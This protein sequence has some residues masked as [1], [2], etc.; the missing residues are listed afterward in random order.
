MQASL[1]DIDTEAILFHNRWRSCLPAILKTLATFRAEHWFRFSSCSILRAIALPFGLALLVVSCALVVSC[2]DPKS[3]DS[4]PGQTQ[5]HPWP[6]VDVAEMIELPGLTG[7]PL[8]ERSTG[9]SEQMFTE[10]SVDESG[11]GFVSVVEPE[12][13]MA[14]LYRSGLACGGL[15]IG[16]VDGDGWPDVF[17]AGGAGKNRLYRQVGGNDGAMRFEDITEQAG[18]LG[19]GDDWAG[20]VSMA[21]IDGDGDL[22][23]YVVNYDAPNALFVNQGTS[24]SD[25]ASGKAN[26]TVQFTEQ[27][28]AFAVDIVDACQTSAF[29]DYD[30][31]G[32]LDLYV[33]TNRYED[34][35]GY[36]GNDAFTTVNGKR[37]L[38]PGYEKY[39]LLWEEGDEWGI[40]AYG[41]EDYLL[42]N[43]GGR[44]TDVS[45]SSGINGRGDGLSATWWDANADG[46]MDLYVG[47]DMISQDKF[48]INQGDGTFRDEIHERIPHS[49]WFSMGADVGDLNNDG[50][51]DFLIADMSA[52]NHFKQKTTMGVMGGPIL[53]AANSSLPPQYMRNALYL[54][55]GTARFLEG[56]FLAGLDS[57]DWTWAVKISDFD[58]DGWQDV[59]VSNGTARAMN[60]SDYTF[61]SEQLRD[62][63]EWH[64]LKSL[65]RREEKNRAMRNAASSLHF[66]DVSDAW[67]LGK[68]GVSYGAAS[69]DLDRDGDVDL[70]VINVEEPVSVYRNDSETGN[71]LILKLV[72]EDGKRLAIG[73]KVSLRAGGVQQQR[74]LAPTSG[75]MSMNEPMLHFGVG[76]AEVIERLVVS[77]PGGGVQEYAELPVNQYFVIRQETT[78][79]N[80]AEEEVLPMFA[81][82]DLSMQ[83]HQEREFDDFT[84]Q[85][86]L[87]N[88]LSQLGSGTAW[89]D[90]DGD[91]DDDL[92]VG[93]AAGQIAELRLNQGNGVFVAQWVEVLREDKA[94]EDMGAVFFDADSDGDQDLYVVSGSYEFPGNAPELADRLYLNDGKGGLSKAEAGTIP[95]DQ[96][97]GSIVAAADFDRDG[98]EDLFVGGRLIPGEYP[99]A[100]QSALLKNEGGKFTDIA[101]EI[102]GLK[103]SGM[104]TSALWSDA[105]DDGWFDLFVTHEWGS[106]QIFMNRAGTL[107]D[108]TVTAGLG[109]RLGWWNSIAGGD[110]DGDGDMDYAVGNHGLNSKYHASVDKPVQLYYGDYTGDGNMNLVEAE[111]EDDVLYPIRGKS[112]SSNAMPHLRDKFQSFRAFATAT[113][114]EIYS[115]ENLQEAHHFVA[116]TLESGLLINDGKGVFTWRALPQLAQIAP[117]FGLTFL[118]ADGDGNLDLFLAQ[119]F[120]GPQAETGRFD[121]GMSLLLRGDGAGG[122]APVGAEVSG[123]IISGDATSVTVSDIDGDHRPDLLVGVNDGFSIAWR[124]QSA[125]D[126]LV[127]RLVGSAAGARVTV[128]D[129]NGTTQ[130]QEIYSG[131]GYLSQGGRSLFFASKGAALTSLEVQWPDGSKTIQN[132][133]D[134]L[135]ALVIVAKEEQ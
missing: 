54:G 64:Y 57:T 62:H 132:I 48:Y 42:R 17:L 29:C 87:P 83:M 25:K 117:V 9:D 1:C 67:G 53:K 35:R 100:P 107:N 63:H 7:V 50:H 4:L 109:E 99:L 114:D 30:N 33:L 55:T 108:A 26:G 73:A 134:T 32:D 110:V 70:I 44:F 31:D 129:S 101:S 123:L 105:N 27:A 71:R 74:E 91:G 15:A 112:C 38:K 60:D 3:E 82:E 93:G 78:D 39:Y 126:Y 58:N 37:T 122:F 115:P 19:G 75:F 2:G 56:A 90:V 20:G 40:R 69:G 86:L 113:L 23:I 47:N 41:R 16:D 135:P 118:D 85:P 121:G 18:A 128:T 97:S 13:P 72:A 46:L 98:D 76:D 124:N 133:A 8:R 116:N 12:H 89:G 34:S 24:G 81:R 130:S 22:D 111:F 95:A 131:G 10:L 102:E 119:N 106:V 68:E 52:T 96:S 66:D 61:T 120:F 21:D 49:S 28:K 36:K 92:F 79:G 125:I 5:A 51:Q 88:K 59:F 43:D 103:E 11:I 127:I 45:K 104:V 14:Y 80:A 77:W 6:P 65:P 84:L 94:C